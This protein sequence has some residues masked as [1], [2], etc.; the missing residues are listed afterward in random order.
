MSPIPALR[1]D[2]V[3]LQR[4]QF[5]LHM[6]THRSPLSEVEPNETENPDFWRNKGY[7]YEGSREKKTMMTTQPAQPAYL[8]MTAD[9]SNNGGSLVKSACRS[10]AN[11]EA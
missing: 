2:G 10:N 5:A 4:F 7:G 6:L 1:L 8:L 11:E 9:M 3:T